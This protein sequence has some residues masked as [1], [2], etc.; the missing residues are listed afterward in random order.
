MPWHAANARA[1]VSRGAW[2]AIRVAG[3]ATRAHNRAAHAKHINTLTAGACVLN[4][5]AQ[6]PPRPA[7][8]YAAAPGGDSR[9]CPAQRAKRTTMPGGCV[10]AIDKSSV[11]RICSGQ[12]ILDLATSVKEL[13]EN[14]L[15]A[16]A[17]SVEVRSLWTPR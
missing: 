9:T 1:R 15:D 16:E 4:E 14:S 12:V 3:R 2:L 17:T 11:H 8:R 7:A 13:V 5:C 10:A 6:S